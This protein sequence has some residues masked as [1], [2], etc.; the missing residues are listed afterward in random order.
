MREQGAE[1][2]RFTCPKP[3]C[4][5]I[6]MAKPPETDPVESFIARWQG[7][8]GGQE[9][10]N[11]ALV[12]DRAVRR[13][14]PAASDPADADHEHN[15]YVFERAVA[16]AS[17]RRRHHRPHRSLQAQLLRARSQAEPPEGRRRRR[18]P[19][20]TICSRPTTTTPDAARVAPSRA[21]DVL[22]L[23]AKRQAED[24]ARGAARRRMAGRRSSSSATSATA[25]RSMPTSPDRERTTPSFPTGRASA[26]ISKTCASRRSASAL[27]RDLDRSAVARSDARSREGHARHRR[28]ARRGV[29]GAG[30]EEISGRRGRA[31]S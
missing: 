7:H 29:E 15:D 13:A 9:R 8:E 4:D 3:S 11:Y 24:Y 14:R 26:S 31:C 6:A 1:M 10:A 27:A 12:P 17:R 28:A 2:P 19:A 30:G 16:A 22:M 5:R 18:S 20:R 23:N 21:W 25:S